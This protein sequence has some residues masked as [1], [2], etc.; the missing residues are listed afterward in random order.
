MKQLAASP[1]FQKQLKKLPAADQQ[2]AIDT[3]KQFLT[4]L[5]SGS[6]PAG[7][8]FKKVNGD[9]YEIRVD[10]KKRIVMK[11]EDDTF[12]CHLIGNHEDV[13]RYLREYRNR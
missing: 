10:L 8:G 9:K 4:A 5:N 11:L 12:V 6:L 7:Y 13:R 3:L 1:H 2:K